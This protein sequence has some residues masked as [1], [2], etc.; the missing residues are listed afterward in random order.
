MTPMLLSPLPAG[1][2]SLTALDLYD[3]AERDGTP[4]TLTLTLDGGVWSVNLLG[5]GAGRWWPTVRGLDADDGSVVYDIDPVD[6]PV[7][8][9]LIV[10]PEKVA[11]RARIPLQLTAE[12]REI[13]T[14]EILAAQSDVA[15]YLGR[16]SLMPHTFTETARFPWGDG[17]NLEALGDAD[18]IEVVSA[19]AEEDVNGL[20]GFYTVTYT[21]GLNARDDPA[22]GG[23]RRY[24]VAHT[25]N[26]PTFLSMWRAL[27]V[28]IAAREIRSVSAEGQA[29]SWSPGGFGGT[30]KAG[31]AGTLP[32]LASLDRWRI[33]GR[34]VHQATTR[35][36][37]W[38][39]TGERW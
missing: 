4:T 2:A 22:L 9:D 35:A 3:T 6:L 32:T 29:V 28:G 25:M 12:Q 14:D 11:V 13:I 15:D 21:A 8:D 31:E 27:P 33:A 23:I 36:S 30:G 16:E 20:T 5:I 10:S 24:V 18:L 17:W 7:R 34:R 38:P 19:V 39:Y 37:D 26:S 1:V